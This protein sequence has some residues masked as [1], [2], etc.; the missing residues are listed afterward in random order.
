MFAGMSGRAQWRLTRG[1]TVEKDGSVTFS[2]WAP[3]P[4]SLAVRVLGPDGTTRAELPM[5]RDAAGVFVARVAAE[6]ARAGDDYAFV[7]PE[8]GPRPDPVSRRQPNGVHAASRIVAPDDFA[9]T[10]GG[11]R[12][13]PRAELIFYELHVGTFTPEGTFDAVIG[14]LP[15]LRDLGITA[16]EIMPVASFPGA[17]NWGYDGVYLYA[18]H[19]A[20]GGPDGFKRLVDACHGH[21]MALFLDVVYNH[22]GPEGNYLGE[23]GPYFSNRYR[24]PWGGALN[25]DGPDSDEVRRFFIDNALFWLTEYHVDGLRLDAIHGIFDFGARPILQELADCFREEAQRLGR[26]AWL[27]A[28]SDLND[29]RVIRDARHGGYGIDAQWSDDF[30]HALH[31]VLTGARR[32]YFSDF[33]RVEQLAKAVQDSFAYEGQHA[34]HRRRCHGAPAV[35]D[36]GERFVAFIQNHDQ[37]ANGYQGRRLAQVAGPDRQKVAAVMLFSTPA[38]PLLFQGEERADD[39]P[40]DYFTSHGDPALAQAV[41]DGRHAEY[42]HLLEEG[43]DATV[44]ADPQSEATFQRSK[45]HW[46]T[47]CDGVHADMLA[48][49]RRLIA[50]RRRL[51][52]LHNNR[53]DL[54][55]LRYDEAGRW[56]VIERGDPGGG[57]VFTAANLGDAPVDV[58]APAGGGGPWRLA[59]ATRR[60]GVTPE[61]VSPGARLTIPAASAF[62]FE[63]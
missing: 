12:G 5:Q 36:P 46:D 35:A 60:D 50:L 13:L 43:A 11:W 41:R 17:R 24:T 40:F 54:T 1:A 38:L 34:P 2:V 19:E 9:W 20:Y 14:K 28:E 18:P 52:P 8:H 47:S 61:T 56:I 31:A 29:P 32:G 23:Y 25:F 3:R 22:L 26:A 15:Y 55:A 7:L 33:G 51:P 27:V 39:A 45:L 49:Y 63:R 30:H 21:G 4:A 42:L 48:F 58:T 62:I 57:A 53:K 37:V 44:W 16:V 59:I 6:Q 10:D